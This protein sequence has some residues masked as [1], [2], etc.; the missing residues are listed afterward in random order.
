M[1]KD[2]VSDVFFNLWNSKTDLSEIVELKAYLF[3]SVKNQAI[4]ANSS[5]P[6]KFQ[7]HYHDE[8][9]RSVEYINPEDLMIGKELEHFLQNVIDSLHPQCQLVFRML[10]EDNLKYTEVAE[11]LDISTSTVKH[12]LTTALRK[13]RLEL[14]DHFSE[15]PVLKLISSLCV[16]LLSAHMILAFFQ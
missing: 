3:T 5:D 14:S 7:S 15:T 1:A 8:V 9:C 11:A 6:A 13:I 16:F 4:R 12:H 10:R 2:V